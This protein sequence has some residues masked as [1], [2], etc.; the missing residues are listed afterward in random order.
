MLE[1]DQDFFPNYNPSPNVRAELLEEY[2]GVA[3]VFAP[4]AEALDNETMT[5][6]NARVDVEGQT[7]EDVAADW[8]ESE[9]IVG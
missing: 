2:P 7:P 5:E 1:D 6:L 4:I 9:G 3:D 8:L